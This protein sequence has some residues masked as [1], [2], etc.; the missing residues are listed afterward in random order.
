M[1][2]NTPIQGS[3]ADILKLAM[4][5]V[6][7]ALASRPFAEMLLTVHDELIFE[8]DEDRV[9][10]LIAVAKPLMEG[11]FELSVP[12]RVEAGFGRTWAEAKA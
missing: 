3:A 12:V 6:E 8:C 11:A 1:A 4:I 5:A 9:D 2:R 7:R 10:D